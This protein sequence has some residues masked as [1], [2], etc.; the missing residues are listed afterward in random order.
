MWVKGVAHGLA[1]AGTVEFEA[2][3]RN[4][5]SQIFVSAR[6]RV[7]GARLLEVASCRLSSED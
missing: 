6:H 5:L 7:I 2:D 4:E 1:D 3:R